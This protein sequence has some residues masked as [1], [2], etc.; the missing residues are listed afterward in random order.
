MWRLLGD[1]FPGIGILALHG[2]ADGTGETFI[3]MKAD[4]D[5]AH[6]AQIH[7]LTVT[8]SLYG[9]AETAEDTLHRQADH[10]GNPPIFWSTQK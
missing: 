5:P 10:G 1:Q 2:V 8:E 7:G 4:S 3:Q 6:G 9:Q